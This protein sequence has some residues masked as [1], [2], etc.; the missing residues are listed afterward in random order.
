MLTKEQRDEILRLAYMMSGRHYLAS[1]KLVAFLDTLTVPSTE[2]DDLA[3]DAFAAA[4]KAKLAKKR[5]E[6]RGGWDDP[7]VCSV[8]F[9]AQ[10]LHSH[11]IKGDPVDVANFAMMLWHRGAG[12]NTLTVPEGWKLV[13]MEPTQKMLEAAIYDT[14][15]DFG[16]DDYEATIGNYQAMLAAAPQP[17]D[18]NE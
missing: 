1:D 2:P 16:P 10:M 13:P 17:G 6:G 9:L 5:A 4:M 7:T 8:A 11:I 18:S 15:Q 3:V 12:T 14:S